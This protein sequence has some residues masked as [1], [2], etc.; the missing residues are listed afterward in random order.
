MA[1]QIIADNNA[2]WGT[3]VGKMNNNFQELYLACSVAQYFVFKEAGQSLNV[4]I[5]QRNGGFVVDKELVVGGFSGVEG[6]GWENISG[7][8]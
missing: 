2:Q 6:T 7:A 3:E 4:R 8:I 1:R 5:G